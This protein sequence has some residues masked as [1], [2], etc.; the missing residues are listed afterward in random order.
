MN[1]EKDK[2]IKELI[3][4]SNTQ[5]S[6]QTEAVKRL[7]EENKNLKAEIAALKKQVIAQP[8]APRSDDDEASSSAGAKKKARKAAG[9][10]KKETVVKKEKV[11]SAS[12]DDDEM[13]NNARA[14]N[15]S[16]RKRVPRQSSKYVDFN[17]EE[18]EANYTTNITP[19]ISTRRPLASVTSMQ[20]QSQQYDEP[21][22][23][24]KTQ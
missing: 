11:S 5:A 22:L 4:L 21:H 16:G 6:K 14:A 24:K 23:Q 15:S 7:A 18:D 10:P 13:V 9:R 17:D 2:K 12:E 3:D 20:Q 1:V 8:K 19:I